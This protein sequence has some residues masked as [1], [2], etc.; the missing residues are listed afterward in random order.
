MET[1]KTREVSLVDYVFSLVDKYESVDKVINILLESIGQRYAF[2]MISVKEM[3]DDASVKCSYEWDI[4]GNTEYVNIE[5]R[6]LENFLTNLKKDFRTDKKG[7]LIYQPDFID[8]SDDMINTDNLATLIRVPI[9]KNK[10]IIGYID[11]IDRERSNYCPDEEIIGDLIHFSRIFASY[12]FP[13]REM[14]DNEITMKQ[15][16]EYDSVTQLPKFEIFR[17]GINNLVESNENVSF[18]FISIDFSNFKFL[19]EKYG[20]VQGNR[21]LQIFAQKI[22]ESSRHIISC[23][24]PYSDNFI[25]AV[26]AYEGISFNTIKQIIELG[27]DKVIDEIQGL[28]FDCNIIINAGVYFADA[29]NFDLNEAISNATLAR[30]FAK[31]SKTN[32]S[33]RC[34]LYNE[35][36]AMVVGKQAEYILAMNKAI[37]DNDFF[38]QFQPI[39]MTDTFAVIGAEALVRWRKDNLFVIYP[40]DF[41]PA[42]EKSGCMVK[43]DYYVYDKVFAYIRERLNEGKLVVPISVNVSIVHFYSNDLVNYLRTLLKKYDIPSHL[44]EIELNEQIYTAKLPNTA[45]VIDGLKELGFKIFIDDFGT[46]YSSLNT[47]TEYAIDGIKLDRSFMKPTLQKDDKIII[48][49]MVNMANKLN[50]EVICEGVENENQ[51]TFLVMNDCAY[52]Q[53]YYSSMPLDREQFD[54]MLD[55]QG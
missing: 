52:M 48:S 19:N 37:L 25:V 41:I 54:F 46:G 3:I 14:G 36:M 50:L 18:V 33:S 40:D 7:L 8:R 23:C 1:E 13:M 32:Q 44:V 22:Y 53:G 30:K 38:V 27:T 55:K 16:S 20:Y 42:F 49:C 26:R 39:C 28:F 15:Y 4:N 21:I 34:M 35:G 24:R 43:L 12:L 47:L 9:T 51:R 10:D 45:A 17:D 2:Q 29:E 11:F 5:K 31:K 6:Y